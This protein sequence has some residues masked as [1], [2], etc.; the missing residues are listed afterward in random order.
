M[1]M[2]TA[3]E[4]PP[5]ELN[6]LPELPVSRWELAS[7]I[8]SCSNDALLVFDPEL[9]EIIEANAKAC[10]MLGYSRDELLATHM[11]AILPNEMPKLVDF[12]RSKRPSGEGLIDELICL[13]KQGEI[14]RSEISASVLE[15]GNRREIIA[16]V[17]ELTARKVVKEE[18]AHQAFH[19]S[20]TGLAN[21]QLFLDRLS[22]SLARGERHPARVAVLFFDLDRFK[23]VNDSFGHEAGDQL[24]MSLANRI[25]TASRPSDT[26]ARFGGDEFAILC[27]D[28]HDEA[29]ATTI[30]VRI[31]EAVQEPFQVLGYEIVLTASIGVALSRGPDDHPA[32]L[33]RNADAA[34]YRAKGRGKDR[35]ELFDEGMRTRAKNRLR[36]E[37]ILRQ[38]LERDEFRIFYQPEVDLRT[39]EIV[40]LEALVRWDNPERGLLGTGEFLAL[41]EETKIIVALGSWVLEEACLQAQRWRTLRPE[42]QSL[43]LAVNLSARQMNQSDLV[44]VVERVLAATGTA[45]S[46]LCLEITESAVMEDIDSSI[47]D[48]LALKALG[49]S[50]A[51]D[52][53]GKGY[54]SL[55]FLK[56]L[57]VDTLKIDQSFIQGLG[58]DRADLAISSGI[59]SMA[60]ALDVNP[61]AEGIETIQQLD[62]LLSLD[63]D[64]GQGYYF[65]R[66]QC[67]TDV[68]E[69]LGASRLPQAGD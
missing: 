8:L 55:S 27:E 29:G 5:W 46:T 52:D 13:T 3:R 58:T 42:R 28:I 22:M 54:T 17:R 68:D 51:I 12:A 19:D 56:R 40:A 45:P 4:R 67:V 26:V 23:M 21:R 30:A 32:S 49:V 20:L 33:L 10:K 1:R 53:L 37:S 39:G 34:M 60:H 61:I 41:A 35:Y 15:L 36:S 44:G 64:L 65:A 66:P 48:L 9:D 25:R 24:L 63:C 69:L 16:S 7:R 47:R 31:L 14:I 2:T 6:T 62:V 59:I 43:T 57:P 18:L 38:A 11:S 50:L